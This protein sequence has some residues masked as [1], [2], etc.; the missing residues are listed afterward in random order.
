M[1]ISALSIL[2]TRDGLTQTAIT[3]ESYQNL[4]RKV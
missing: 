3:P 1:H 4:R 2:K